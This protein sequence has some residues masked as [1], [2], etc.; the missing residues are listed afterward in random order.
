[1]TSLIQSR[2]LGKRLLDNKNILKKL[3]RNYAENSLEGGVNSFPVFSLKPNEGKF[4]FDC[5][6]SFEKK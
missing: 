5:E 1:M 2:N 6:N 3:T 4:D